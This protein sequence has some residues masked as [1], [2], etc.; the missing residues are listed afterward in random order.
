MECNAWSAAHRFSH[1]P[2]RVAPPH[3]HQAAIGAAVPYGDLGL[4]QLLR[5]L[6]VVFSTIGVVGHLEEVGR[7]KQSSPKPMVKYTHKD[8]N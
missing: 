2:R 6:Q 1:S 5:T 7:R 4:F 8:Y 3:E